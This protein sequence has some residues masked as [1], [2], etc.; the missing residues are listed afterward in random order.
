[1][2][3]G[4]LLLPRKFSFKTWQIWSF[5]CF[6]C[7]FAAVP[8]LLTLQGDFLAENMGEDNPFSIE[9]LMLV[10]AGINAVLC[11]VLAGIGLWIASRLGLGLPLIEDALNETYDRKK[12]MRF[13][14]IAILAG[15][16]VSAL[17]IALDAVVFL[18]PL[19]RI[20]EPPGIDLTSSRPT[21]WKG[22]LAAF[23]AGVVEETIYRLFGLSLLI[24]VGF[25]LRKTDD[26]YPLSVVFLVANVI[27]AVVFGV[28]HISNLAMFD[29]ELTTPI[30]IR[31]VVLNGLGALIF[32]WLYWRFGLETAVV[33]HVVTDIILQGVGSLVAHSETIPYALFV[34]V[35]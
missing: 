2:L 10:N 8:F 35:I 15:L 11:V 3:S 17:I 7:A 23:S 33:A 5:I 19:T 29:V 16:V 14:A 13:G 12:I 21:F 24:W 27:I 31:L 32:G 30:V 1:M 9:V 34:Y 22:I 26:G 4:K 18:Q 20:L 6:F 25:R 28:S